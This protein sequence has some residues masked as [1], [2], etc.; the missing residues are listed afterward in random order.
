M[1]FDVDGYNDTFYTSSSS[2]QGHESNAGWWDRLEQKD[3]YWAVRDDSVYSTIGVA[4]KN[5]SK[6]CDK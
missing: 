4:F 2:P 3:H 5:S 1:Q 6:T